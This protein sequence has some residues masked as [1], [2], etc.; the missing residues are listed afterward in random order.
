MNTENND[1]NNEFKYVCEK[2]NYKCQFE[3]QWK[4][5]CETTLHKT[6]E[7]KKK[8]IT[9]NLKNVKIVNI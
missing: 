8:I 5:H 9:N 6:G 2:C 1:L 3:C 4:K 7:R